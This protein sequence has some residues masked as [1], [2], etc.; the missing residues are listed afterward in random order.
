MEEEKFFKDLS[1]IGNPMSLIDSREAEFAEKIAEHREWLRQI[2]RERL[3]TVL[4]YISGISTRRDMRIILIT[5]RSNSLTLWNYVQIGRW[6]VS[7]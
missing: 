3:S 7:I 5:K 1:N 2:R 4:Q 6:W